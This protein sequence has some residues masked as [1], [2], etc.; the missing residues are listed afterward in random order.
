MNAAD[1]SVSVIVPLA[2]GDETWRKLLPQLEMPSSWELLLAT[3]APPYD[4]RAWESAQC[5]W[6]CCLQSGRAAQMNAAA[7]AARGD[8]LW[9]VHADTQPPP[10]AAERLAASLRAHPQALHYFDLK[11]YDG[12][13]K[14]KLN[15]WGVRCR[16]AVFNNP[17]GDQALCVSRARFN[18]I[19][20]FPLATGPGEDHL[21]VLRAAKMGAPIKRVGVA[22][23]TS[24]R[25]YMQRGWWRTVRDYQGIWWRQWRSEK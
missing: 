15:E 19:G 25:N 6:L 4:W 13:V 5:R 24:A 11:F 8:F 14:M 1:I 17:F 7:S 23:E 2:V 16:C 22:V 18:Q 21:F 3:T 10:Q 9:F 20:G 12:G